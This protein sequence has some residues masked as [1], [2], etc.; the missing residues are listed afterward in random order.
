MSS[1]YPLIS[2]KVRIPRRSQSLLRRDRL[3]DFIHSNIHHKVILIAAGAGYGKTSLLIDYAHD[4][5]LP[6]CWYSLDASDAH[7]PT[8]IEYLV[9]SIRQRFPQFGEPVLQM[10]RSRPAPSESVEPFVRLLIHEIEETIDRYFVI[11]L[12]DYQAIDGE[13]VTALVDGLLRYL[14]EHCHIILASRGVPRRLTLTRL[15]ARQEIV[16]LGVEHL[17]FTTEEIGELLRSLGK[18]ELGSEQMCTLAERSEGWITGILLAAQASW[19]GTIQD[20]LQISGAK[21]AVFDYMAE[22]VLARQPAEVQRF[23][24]GSALL[25]EMTPPLCDALLNINNSVQLLSDL[26]AQ[27][28]F[29]YPLDAEGTWYQYH[30]L[31]REFLVAKSERDDPEGHRRLRL[32]QAEIMAH[33]GHWDRAVESFLAAQ[34][35][36]QA[37]DALEV[38]V[39]DTFDAGHWET[40]KAWIDALPEADL[41]HHPRLLLFRAKIH[42]ETGNLG[43]AAALLGR[44][45]QAYL[46]R[47]DSVGAARALMQSAIVQRFRGRLR[48]AMQ[49]C[50]KALDMVGDRDILT[51]TQAHRNMGICH[52]MQGQSGEGIREL[53]EG[54]RLAQENG[55]E[56]NAAYIAHDM[57]AAETMRGQLTRARQHYH[58]ALVYWRKIVNASALASTLQSLG[59]VHHH[60]GQYAKA[61]DRFQEGLARA[62]EAAD[63]RIEA[64]ALASQGDLY[65]DTV[66]YDDA[67]ASYRQAVEI[68]SQAQLTRLG[69]YLLDA[70]GDTYR[71]KGDLDQA[72]QTLREAMGQVRENEMDYEAGLCQLSLGTLDLQEGRP[73]EAEAHLAQARALFAQIG[74][75][76]DLARTMWQVAA[77]A[78]SRGDEEEAGAALAEVGRLAVEL[79][80]HQFIVGEGPSCGALLRYAADRGIVGLDYARIRAE[81]AQLAPSGVSA[82]AVIAGQA[83]PPLEFLGLNGGQVL[84]DGQLV[85]DWESASARTMAFLFITYPDG[86]RRDQV[87]D[88]LWPEVTQAK[89]NSLFHST[90]YRLRRALFRNILVH[91]DGVYRINPRCRYRYDVT[92]FRRLAQAGRGTDGSSAGA[93]AEAIA[94]Y[95]SAF[96]QTCDDEW[97]Y[98]VRESL[99]NE[100]LRLL[101]AQAQY[102]ARAGTMAEA[103]AHYTRALS[104]DSYDERAHRGVM[105]CKAMSSDRAGAMRQFRECVRILRAELDVDPSPETR[106]L[107][108][109]ILAGR[110]GPVPT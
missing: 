22:E 11:I 8:F 62:R 29:T 17:R 64:Y 4:T 93:R 55:D 46:D 45:Y 38:I 61:E 108:E 89:G 80:S 41:A 75:K 33:R 70:V 58:Q 79:G 19:T 76:R 34:A 60:L 63:V 106:V 49:T 85:T 86:M 27:N 15:A 74:A 69:V 40:L 32:R 53:E 107:Y 103:E 7:L 97:C 102:L 31:F 2:T 10:L 110:P 23:L 98:E 100:M 21:G 96:L 20:I 47:G 73:A 65:R 12:D 95:H 28:L 77:L 81:L 42:T 6:V 51:A 82:A 99:Q 59:V 88:T 14:P 109:A 101:L 9:A 39:K 30:Q 48:D 92:E 43:Q 16:G 37:A 54:L 94:L 78:R 68:V 1:P 87:I 25:S 52:I 44:S 104:L 50:R 5:D 90:V 84:K 67:L 72:R 35:F 91:E 18:V 26:S 105:W 56:I 3:V 57:G 36:D 71:L 66:R 24:L 83:T 13:P